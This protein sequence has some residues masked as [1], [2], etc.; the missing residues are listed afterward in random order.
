M[1]NIARI[2]RLAIG[3]VPPAVA[4]V[5]VLAHVLDITPYDA[6]VPRSDVPAA[7]QKSTRMPSCPERGT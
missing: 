1:G 3:R 5:V 4:G 6:S 7:A 2:R